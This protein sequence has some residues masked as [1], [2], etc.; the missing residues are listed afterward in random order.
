MNHKTTWR[1]GTALGLLLCLAPL[2]A[3]SDAPPP[4]EPPATTAPL[5]LPDPVSFALAVEQEMEPA[6]HGL[7]ASHGELARLA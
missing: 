5:T 4:S 7:A 6:G 1:V 3:W 2:P